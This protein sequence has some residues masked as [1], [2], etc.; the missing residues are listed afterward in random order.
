MKISCPANWVRMANSELLNFSLYCYPPDTN[1]TKSAVGM[2]STKENGNAFM[3]AQE[4]KQKLSSTLSKIEKN[5]QVKVIN[6]SYINI[7]NNSPLQVLSSSR[8]YTEDGLTFDEITQK[9]INSFQITNLP[10]KNKS[11]LGH[12]PELPQVPGQLPPDLGPL[13]P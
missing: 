2:E 1:V 3:T 5:G 9:M 6:S 8:H 10:V 13:I 12:V 4:Q 11:G 7:S